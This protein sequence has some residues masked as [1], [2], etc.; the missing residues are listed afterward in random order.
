VR[1]VQKDRTLNCQK[2]DVQLG[3]DK[4]AETMTCTGQVHMVDP[5]SGRTMDSQRAVYRVKQKV[6]EMF[7]EPVTMQDRDKNVVRGRHMIYHSQDG[8]V[9][10]LGA[11]AAG[12]DAAGRGAA[13]P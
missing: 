1:V 8:R 7:G 9:D 12:E 5:Q 13:S 10:V 4:K 6:I 2:L 11:A 3:P